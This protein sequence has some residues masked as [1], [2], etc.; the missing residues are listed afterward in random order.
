MLDLLY[1]ILMFFPPVHRHYDNVSS[2]SGF[3]L[4]FLMVKYIPSLLVFFH[5]YQD[6][7]LCVCVC[8]YV[9]LGKFSFIFLFWELL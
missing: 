1:V 8:I 4:C 5:E 6:L 7:V 2:L 3:V 9:Y